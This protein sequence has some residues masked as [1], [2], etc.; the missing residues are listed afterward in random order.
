MSS[1]SR[2]AVYVLAACAATMALPATAAP[3]APSV[4]ADLAQTAELQQ[5]AAPI[6]LYPDGLLSQVLMAATYPIQVVEAARWRQAHPELADASLETALQEQDWDPS[7]KSLTAVPGVLDMMNE[8]ITWTARLGEVFL[9]Q[10]EALMSQVQELRA[11]AQSTGH[12]SSSPEQIVSLAPTPA[13][14]TIIRIEPQRPE[15]LYVPIYDPIIVYGP[16]RYPTH[17]PFYWRPVG[18]VP[19]NK[20]F[21]FSIGVTIGHALWGGYDWGRYRLR[22]ANLHHYNRFNRTHFTHVEWRHQ[23]RPRRAAP[24]GPARHAQGGQREAARYKAPPGTLSTHPAATRPSRPRDDSNTLGTHEHSRPRQPSD[25]ST[26]GPRRDTTRAGPSS[27]GAR[28]QE[29]RGWG[30]AEG[31]HEYRP[32]RTGGG[33]HGNRPD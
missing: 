5:L 32:G 9:A 20:V 15:I 2:L 8:R 24:Y 16:W 23:P 12:L 31:R 3:N 30:N 28:H 4:Q 14:T 29:N 21:T 6:A 33:H 25:L 22:V 17:R 10:Q 1:L 19:G 13:G 11:Q 18:Y 27:A 7:V 26:Q